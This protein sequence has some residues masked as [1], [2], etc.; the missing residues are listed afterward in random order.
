MAA[1]LRPLT[2][3]AL[4]DELAE[5]EDALL[6]SGGEITAE[7]EALYGDLLE[8]HADKV[9][10]YVAMIRRLETTAAAIAQER[11]RLQDAER[12]MQ[13]AAKS[14][15]NRLHDCMVRRGEKEHLTRL[16]KVKVVRAGGYAPIELLVD[17]A[18]MLP[19]RFRRVAVTPDLEALRE[20]LAA[21]DP[22]AVQVAREG[23][24]STYVRI[25]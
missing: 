22:D 11:K 4:T 13:N 18:T 2:L 9:E 19:E 16:G 24:R 21:G 15:K 12:S 23:E 20:A 5:L 1:S 10:A 25:Y 7:V 3:Y 8:M 6:A 17:E 14:L